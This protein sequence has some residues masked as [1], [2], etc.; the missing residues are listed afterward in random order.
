MSA[1]LPFA[2]VLLPQGRG[3]N[4]GFLES[5]SPGRLAEAY[6]SPALSNDLLSAQAGAVPPMASFGTTA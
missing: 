5:M 4:H 2:G 1:F 3:T 6:R